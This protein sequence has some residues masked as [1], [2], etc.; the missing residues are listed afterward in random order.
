M[1]L[2]MGCKTLDGA[3]PAGLLGDFFNQDHQDMRK[4]QWKN[5]EG[6]R[7]NF[8]AVENIR[9]DRFDIDLLRDFHGGIIN[10]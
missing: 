5:M 9:S 1:A 10:K 3:G 8:H 7:V 2:N 4:N 6:H